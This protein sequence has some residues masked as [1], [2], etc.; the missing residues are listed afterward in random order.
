MTLHRI[1]RA[2]LPDAYPNQ[3]VYDDQAFIAYVDHLD[4]DYVYLAVDSRDQLMNQRFWGLAPRNLEQAMAMRLLDND[5]VDMTVLTGLR[6]RAR[7][8]WP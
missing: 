5:D 7:P 8:S 2:E 1:P 3:F 4:E 6:G